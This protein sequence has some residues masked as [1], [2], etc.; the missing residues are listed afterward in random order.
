MSLSTQCK[1]LFAKAG[2]TSANNCI[3]Y[4]P[5]NRIKPLFAEK[6]IKTGDKKAEKQ[7]NY[8]KQIQLN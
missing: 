2:W 4:T 3:R 7:S 1:E 8:A 5:E 6:K